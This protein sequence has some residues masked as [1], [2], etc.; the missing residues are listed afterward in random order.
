MSAVVHDER[1][2]GTAQAPSDRAAMP[3]APVAREGDARLRHSIDLRHNATATLL[4]LLFGT[5]VLVLVAGLWFGH[6]AKTEPVR[7]IVS[8]TGGI[9][10]LDAPRAGVISAMLVKQGDRVEIGQPVYRLRLGEATAGGETA[11]SAQIRTMLASRANFVDE[12]GRTTKFLAEAQAQAASSRRDAAAVQAAVDEEERSIQAALTEARRRV[13]RVRQFVRQGY[14]TRDLL[15]AQERTAFEYERQLTATRLKRVEYRR[16]DAEKGRDFA[17]MLAGKL[18]QKASAENEVQGIDGNLARMRTEGAFEVQAPRSGFAL[19]IAGQ[20][21]DSVAL[22]QF[23]AAIGDNDADIV[24][25]V[26]APAKA[27]GLIK[28]GQTVILKYDAFPFKTF[29]IQHGTVSSISTAAVRTPGVKDDDGDDPRPVDRQSV[30]RVEIRPDSRTIEAYGEK[31]MLKI[32][33]T[34]SADIVVE[35][36]RLIDWVLDPIRAM[37]GRT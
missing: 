34:L 17:L 30:Y 4:T 12:I 3:A 7:G 25:V 19:A 9:S 5:A 10:R 35:R 31:K 27:I 23:V 18:S 14:A 33:S 22:N 15:E 32:G 28:V 2:A 6:F 26:D 24:V 21:G 36:R 37:R 13:E 29:G 8:A 11:L 1:G 16:A 20:V